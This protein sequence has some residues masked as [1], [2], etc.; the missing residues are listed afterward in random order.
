M[1]TTKDHESAGIALTDALEGQTIWNTS[2]LTYNFAMDADRMAFVSDP[3]TSVHVF[4]GSRSFNAL[5]VS[6]INEANIRRDVESAMA[7]W[8][9]VAI[10]PTFVETTDYSAADIKIGGVNNYDGVA[11]AMYFPGTNVKGPLVVSRVD[12]ESYLLINTSL[13][14]VSARGETGGGH[15]GISLALHELGH[16]LGL[17]HP[18]DA[19][20]GTTAIAARRADDADEAAYD[21]ER[22]TVMSYES[23][24]WNQ[25]LGL[26]Y[27]HAVT[28][29]ALD[30]LAIQTMY[31]ARSSY[32]GNTV[33]RLTDAG[34]AALDLAGSDGT[35][36]IG[37]AFYSIWD[38]GGTD[39]LI[40]SGSNRVL[41]NLNNTSGSVSRDDRT[42][43]LV[44]LI[45]RGTAF[46]ALPDEIKNYLVDPEYSAGGNI[47]TIFDSAGNVQLGGYSIA[48]DAHDADAKIENATGGSGDDVIVGNEGA[49]V[50]TGNLGNDLLLGS[51]GDDSISGG[52]GDDELAGG[53]GNDA[54][55]GGAG[56]DTAL[57]SDVYSNYEL[58]RNDSTGVVTVSHVRGS[59]ADGTDT[60]ANIESARFRDVTVDLTGDEIEAVPIDFIFLVDLSS[61]FSDDLPNFVDSAPAIFDAVRAIDPNA[62]FA[63]SSFIDLPESPHGSEGDYVYRPELALTSDLDTFRAVLSGLTTQDG[64]D[65]PEAQWAGLWGAVNGIGL[66]LRE[67]SRKIVL[68]ATDAP[69][70]SASDYGLDEATIRQFLID[71]SITT[72]GGTTASASA[73]ASAGA[74]VTG[75]AARADTEARPEVTGAP[76]EDII[77]PTD[78]GDTDPDY[79]EDPVDPLLGEAFS[80][81]LGNATVLF[82]VTSD[83]EAFYEDEVP[84]EVASAIAPLSSSGEDIA[85]AVRLALAGVAGVVTEKGGNATDDLLVGTLDNDGLFGLGGNDTII[86]RAGDDVID[87]GSGDDRLNGGE[88]DDDIRGGTGN[89]VI[90]DGMGNDRID[91]G[92]GED[93]IYV[94]AGT[95][96][97]R[98]GLGDDYILGGVGEDSLRGGA[99]DDV[100]KGGGGRDMFVFGPG[101][102]SDVVKD[103][104]GADDRLD[105]TDFPDI[106]GLSDL[107]VTVDAD[108]TTV[109]LA[110]HGG[111][112]VRLEGFTASLEAKHCLFASA[113]PSTDDFAADESTTGTVAA[114]DSATGNIET[115]GD[116]DWFTVEL[117]AGQTYV[118][119]VEGSET[120]AGTLADPYLRGIYD[121]DGNFLSGTS[122]D[123]IGKSQLNSRVT[124]SPTASGTYY[125]AVGAFESSVGTYTVSVTE[126][127]GSGSEPVGEDL[128]ADTTTTGRVAIAGSATGNIETG[129]DRD[130]FA[131]ELVAGRTYLVDLEGSET[132]QGTLED[133]Y[134]HGIHDADGNLVA[135]TSSDDVGASPN[136]RVTFSPTV[137]GTY[138]VAAGAF[139]TGVGT[140]TLS[141]RETSSV[142]EG[143][144]ADLPAD[145]TTTGTV[146]VDSLATGNIGTVKRP[147]LVRGRAGHGPDLRGRSRRLANHSRDAPGSLSSRDSR[148]RRQPHFRHE[149][150]RCHRRHAQ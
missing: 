75:D 1:A 85:D 140:Y 23:G 117:V 61:S 60:L 45:Q 24:G 64:G 86:G 6:D 2:T 31:G 27:G 81:V 143:A 43:A 123:D 145:T 130:W 20:H 100:L 25:I 92:D 19:G 32:E 74:S 93:T 94:F 90:F 70:H 28:P 89:D 137:D 37:R 131:V 98:G 58:S 124:F 33:Y 146:E 148:R 50:L 21:N 82:A 65:I 116:R 107:T 120:S 114:G 56:S 53:E 101:N 12:Y 44:D 72:I 113:T 8:S 59:R 106:T 111:G 95:N 112:E 5:G 84:D 4:T 135:D 99:G 88:G 14:I 22:Y 147:G 41:L 119:D 87:G 46:D 115:G 126:E 104:S 11:G 78:V 69:A 138:Y 55:D 18:H 122:N 83:A 108:G 79:T 30:I 134:L 57:F 16:G 121:S 96:D 66:K 62:Q 132:D 105:F 125:V 49:N 26:I 127:R 118:V 54:L 13:P 136:S 51:A 15:F 40:Y 71:N 7:A 36:S 129:D 73:S 47:S 35:I 10:I 3:S 52:E 9:R 63:I 39:S 128:P 133:P 139:S 149:Q 141:V 91:G 110:A 42:E 144:G 102:G 103:F 97:V 17:A 80:T 109:S 150:R 34:S 29:M 38:T 142:S 48:S 68:V 67:N 76:R 77:D